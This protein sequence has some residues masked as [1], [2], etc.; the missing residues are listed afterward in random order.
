MQAIAQRGINYHDE[1]HQADFPIID[2]AYVTM[3][4]ESLSI[5]DKEYSSRTMS[6]LELCMYADGSRHQEEVIVT[7]TKGRLEAYLPENKVYAFQRP[8]T[9]L[10]TDRTVPPPLGAIKCQVWDCSD[11]AEVHH[12]DPTVLPKHG[13]YHYGSTAVEWYK[14]LN[15]FRQ[16]EETGI[17]KPLVSLDDGIRAVEMGLQATRALNYHNCN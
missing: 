5:S 13:G 10:W 14:L 2:A 15:A 17:W 3:P 16:Y 9:D 8:S 6:C 1:P 11:A 7:G 12:T 4:W